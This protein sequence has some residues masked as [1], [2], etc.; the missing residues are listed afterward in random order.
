MDVY[1]SQGSHQGA[2]RVRAYH[3]HFNFSKR[4]ESHDKNRE[5][6]ND[7]NEKP[8]PKSIIEEAL[9]IIEGDREQT[10]GSPDVNLKR[11]AFFWQT[12]L[13]NKTRLNDIEI[14]AEDVCWMMVLMKLSRQLHKSKRDNMVDAIGYIA[15]IDKIR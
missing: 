10:Y 8:S 6:I 1:T 2:S 15:L 12:N 7:M 4:L 11:I 5:D 3:Y 9:E 14:T 13:A